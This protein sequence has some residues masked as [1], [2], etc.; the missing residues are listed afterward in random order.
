MLH[1]RFLCQTNDCYEISIR[2]LGLGLVDQVRRWE[3]LE[4]G[5]IF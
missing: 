4:S 1:E 3:I 5:Q 2:R